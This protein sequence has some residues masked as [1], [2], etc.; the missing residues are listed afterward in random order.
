ME[1]SIGTYRDIEAISGFQIAMAMESEGTGT[2]DGTGRFRA[3][4]SCRSIVAKA[5]SEPCT[6][7]SSR[8]PTFA[9]AIPRA[10][11]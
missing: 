11:R 7:K 9:I 6:L 8:G 1:I 4:M 2:T 5:F 3:Y 10:I